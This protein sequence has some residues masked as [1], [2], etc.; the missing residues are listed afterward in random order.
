MKKHRRGRGEGSITRRGDGR[1]QAAV[2]LGYE[3]GKRKRRF[4]YGDTKEELAK[5]LRT[6]LHQR[7][8]GLPLPAGSATLAHVH[9]PVA[10]TYPAN[11]QAAQL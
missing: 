7:D 2:S 4:L 11:H 1:W 3:D 8:V 9:D 10:G 5:Q 6:M